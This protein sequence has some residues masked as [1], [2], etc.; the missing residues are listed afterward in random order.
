M[1]KTAP[2]HFA[3]RVSFLSTALAL[4]GLALIALSSVARADGP[5]ESQ[6]VFLR[7]GWALQSS[8]KFSATG[9]QISTVG[10]KTDGWH[11]ASVP[12]TVVAALVADK[13]Y[14]DPYYGKNL[15]D[16]PGTTYPIGKNFSA[17]LTLDAVVRLIV[18]VTNPLDRLAT[19]RAGL[20]IASVHRHILSKR[21]Y[22][23]RKAGF[24]LV[25]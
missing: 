2:K 6:K 15:R 17:S 3:Q 13:T 1:K 18:C 14:P 8:C 24:R 20:S 23:F 22:L 9:E 19:T 25:G 16:I 11:S 4:G 21:C 7:S 5:Q 10:F 12:T